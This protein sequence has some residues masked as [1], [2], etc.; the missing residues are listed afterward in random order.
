MA[1][2]ASV[3]SAELRYL[4]S[5]TTFSLTLLVFLISYS[6]TRGFLRAISSSGPVLDLLGMQDVNTAVSFSILS[7]FSAY[8]V[9]RER[10]HR[11]E[12]LVFSKC[13][14][15]PLLAMRTTG[16]FFISVSFVVALAA[17]LV[18]S[19]HV[20]FGGIVF[21]LLSVSLA[22][23]AAFAIV[24]G[25][26]ASGLPAPML[27]AFSLAF[28]GSWFVVELA[29][30][31]VSSRIPLEQLDPKNVLMRISLGFDTL[32]SYGPMAIF[33]MLPL[34]LSPFREVN[35]RV[36]SL[37]LLKSLTWLPFT[38]ACVSV[39]VDLAGRGRQAWGRQRA[40]HGWLRTSAAL[41]LFSVSIFV[42][43]AYLE[44]LCFRMFINAQQ[45]IGCERTHVSLLG[46]SDRVR[47]LRAAREAF[48]KKDG[49]AAIEFS[50]LQMIV[51]KGSS[52][53]VLAEN[54]LRLRLD[55]PFNLSP[56]SPLILAVPFTAGEVYV[57]DLA[58]QV[59]YATAD[60]FQQ[61]K[62][63]L[64]ESGTFDPGLVLRIT[65]KLPGLLLTPEGQ[66]ESPSFGYLGC[67]LILESKS[68]FIADPVFRGASGT[69]HYYPTVKVSSAIGVSGGRL[70]P[71]HT[72]LQIL[73]FPDSTPV[74]EI[75]R[76][77]SEYESQITRKG[78]SLYVDSA[79]KP[80]RLL[81]VPNAVV[82]FQGKIVIAYS[83][84]DGE[85]LDSELLSNLQR[86][87]KF[88]S[89]TLLTALG[90][91]IEINPIQWKG[92]MRKLDGAPRNIRTVYASRLVL[93]QLVRTIN[94][95]DRYEVSSRVSLFRTP[96]IGECLPD[97]EAPFLCDLSEVGDLVAYIWLTKGVMAIPEEAKDAFRW[98]FKKENSQAEARGFFEL[99]GTLQGLN[100]NDFLL[101]FS[102]VV[103]GDIRFKDNKLG[104]E[105]VE[106]YLFSGLSE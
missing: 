7:S 23:W 8:L 87:D 73:H 37:F 100:E 57:D 21:L 105:N 6:V 61:E 71:L 18:L 31:Y 51:S 36:L 85:E 67:P 102:K 78:D 17:G 46:Q 90:H 79:G 59:Y 2:L 69:S 40:R 75:A 68:D 43:R 28:L 38:L 4:C 63:L 74:F 99:L 70:P 29:N 65:Y 22:Y 66:A 94:S 16:I 72:G 25:L 27:A 15:R 103:N 58:F 52:E 82:A 106:S 33:P 10:I 83:F 1:K 19:R 93:N 32:R 39:S 50:E 81:G 48:T 64:I 97:F 53:D 104:W 80:P 86:L 47:L 56:S 24:S 55:R 11:T 3:F 41:V 54:R 45:R 96:K 95:R 49:R 101:R 20:P 34:N 62:W 13:G 91:A 30:G 42:C 84:L 35:H 12:G 26:V 9:N 77:A 88:L 14:V 89:D 76:E 44:T 92:L 98:V 5:K 60:R